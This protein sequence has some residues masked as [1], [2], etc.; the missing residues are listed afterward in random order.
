MG[1]M[2]VERKRGGCLTAFL[3]LMLVANPLTAG[4]YVLA[5]ETVRQSLPNLPGWAIPVLAVAAV[6][7]FVFAVGVW[8][9]K[10]WGVYGLFVSAALV[11]VL[12][13][14]IV[15]ILPAL[16]GIIGPVILFFLIRPVWSQLE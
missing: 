3:I 5:G 10:R 14:F 12:N 15:G 13:T 16:V 8:M 6:L 1:S 2:P 11:F 4:Y 9:W 7:N